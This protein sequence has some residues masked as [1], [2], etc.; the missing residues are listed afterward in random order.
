[1]S[2]TDKRLEKI[3]ANPVNDW[4]IGDLES[5]AARYGVAVYREGGS[6]VVFRKEPH[7]HVTVP[8]HRPIKPVYLKQFI[9]LIDM[10]KEQQDESGSEA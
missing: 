6:H 1:M 7:M 2:K 9:A 8:A 4:Q 3:R 10:V 5:I